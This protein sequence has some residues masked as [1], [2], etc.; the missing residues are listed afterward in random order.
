MFVLFLERM[1]CSVTH[2]ISMIL[3]TYICAVY[4]R[5]FAEYAPTF[6]LVLRLACELNEFGEIN[7][8]EKRR[9]GASKKCM[10]KH[11]GGS[12]VGLLIPALESLLKRVEV[13]KRACG[14]PR[15]LTRLD[16]TGG[17]P[18]GGSKGPHRL[19]RGR[20]GGGETGPM[21]TF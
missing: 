1:E 18:S 19:S 12:G 4:V 8:T 5:E 14:G 21:R 17:P 16:G 11:G 7:V 13:A 10:K 20:S 3:H 6:T 9:A 15:R 2:N